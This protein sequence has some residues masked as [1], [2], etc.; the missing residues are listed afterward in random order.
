M[1]YDNEIRWREDEFDF[2]LSNNEIGK[3]NG[4][5]SGDVVWEEYRMNE[6]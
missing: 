2:T 3:E 6:K 1:E 4:G 5:E